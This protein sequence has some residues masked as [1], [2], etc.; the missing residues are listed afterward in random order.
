[1]RIALCIAGY[2]GA[3][4][5][6]HEGEKVLIDISEGYSYVKENIIRDHDVDT[7]IF[8]FDTGRK[9][10]ILDIYNPISYG[11]EEQVREFKINHNNYSGVKPNGHSIPEYIFA[12]QSQ[13]YSRKKVVE[14][15]SKYEEENGFKYDWVVIARMDMAYFKPFVFEGK[16]PAKLYLPGPHA[17]EKVND[18]FMFSGTEVMNKVGN[19][20]N[21]IENCSLVETLHAHV[22]LANYLKRCG[23]WDKLEYYQWRPWGDPVWKPG[24]IGLLRLKP[25]VKTVLSEEVN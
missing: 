16:D 2:V 5:K 13:H 23:L 25:N 19:F 8:S 9:N 10:E 20:Y 22:A 17:S 4:K 12:T 18:I 7:F 6:F 11:I 24:D 21:D 14:L 15:K 1:M 3:M